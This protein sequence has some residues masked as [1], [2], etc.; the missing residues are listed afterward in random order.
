MTPRSGVEDICRMQRYMTPEYFRT[1]T[2]IKPKEFVPWKT[3]FY[4]FLSVIPEM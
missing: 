3:I 1:P 2:K 4:Y